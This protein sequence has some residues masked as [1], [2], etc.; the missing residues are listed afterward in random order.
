M[1]PRRVLQVRDAFRVSQPNFYEDVLEVRIDKPVQ[2]APS[3]ST[4]PKRIKGGSAKSNSTK[5]MKKSMRVQ[6]VYTVH[7]KKSV[8]PLRAA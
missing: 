8:I 1:Q 4:T 5:T 3:R 7:L 6:R 2:I